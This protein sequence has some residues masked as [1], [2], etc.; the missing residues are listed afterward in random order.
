MGFPKVKKG[1]VL[2]LILKDFEGT[3][4]ERKRA[5]SAYQNEMSTD[6]RCW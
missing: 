2:G 5:N 4:K 1:V 6:S 3:T